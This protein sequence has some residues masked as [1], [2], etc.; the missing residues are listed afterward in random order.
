MK[1]N[2]KLIKVLNIKIRTLN[3][4]DVKIESMLK[5]C[6]PENDFLSKTFQ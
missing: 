5:L 6:G 4:S 2:Y 3:L 1:L